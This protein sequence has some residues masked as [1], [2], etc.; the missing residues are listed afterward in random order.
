VRSVAN[1]TRGD[2]EDFLKVAAEIP[3]HTETQVF[4]LEETNQALNQLKNDAVRGA[5]VI[6][7][8]A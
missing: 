4:P 7:V 1:N 5:A 2:G 8:A 3:I 6:Q